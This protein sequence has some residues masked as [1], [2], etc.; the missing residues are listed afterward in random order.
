[1]RSALFGF[2]PLTVIIVLMSTLSIPLHWIITLCI[3]AI[4]AGARHFN[5]FKNSFKTNLETSSGDK[6][7]EKNKKVD[8]FEF[9]ITPDIIGFFAA[10][11]TVALLFHGANQYPYLEDDDPWIH[12]LGVNQIAHT[13]S[14]R[15]PV[16]TNAANFD[17]WYLEPYPPAFD[18]LL[19]MLRQL[20][21]STVFTLKFF[22]ALLAGVAVFAF[23]FW[24]KDLFSDS[25][26]LAPIAA[27]FIST[28]PGF[29]SHFIWAQTL[30]MVLV[31]VAFMAFV[32]LKQD[33]SF[34]L[35]T[36]VCVSAVLVTQPTVAL[37]FGV[38]SCVFLI[39]Q[40]AWKNTEFSKN[41]FIALVGGLLLA[42][43]I[44]W[45]PAFLK[46]GEKQ[47]LF[48]LGFLSSFFHG[49]TSD[50]TSGGVVYN[51]WDF[52][53]PP[54]PSKMDQAVGIGF[55][56]VLLTLIALYSIIK[57]VFVRKLKA[58]AL[59]I[60][61]VAF[62]IIGFLGVQGNA[63]PI[64]LFPHRFWVFLAIPVA[65]FGAL[66]IE[67]IIVDANPR[68]ALII[69]I[70]GLIIFS[71]SLSPRIEVQT[72]QWPPGAAWSSFDEV[73][74]YSALLLALPPDT[75]VFPI[76]A[77]DSKIAGFD[78]LSEPWDSQYKE[79]KKSAFNR[80]SDEVYTFLK[81]RGY[82]YLIIDVSCVKIASPNATQEKLDQYA[83]SKNYEF[84]KPSIKSKLNSQTQ[85]IQTSTA[86]LFRLR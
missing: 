51:L 19:G 50:D 38:I 52:L 27:V 35:Q 57:D 3:G 86:F 69:A 64:K 36:L 11:F 46:F 2:A 29:M 28:I 58:D 6:K 76:C 70:V 71:T 7:S 45:V 26:W 55:G 40:F 24:I 14:A 23:Y 59:W 68:K 54:V 75:K 12:A 53:F 25:K 21:N 15:M 30:A 20:N 66:V 56:L 79:F 42:C 8:C 13:F 60:F 83:S 47:F 74:E 32:K 82:S 72:S 10:L 44:F 9:R 80:S 16:E 81:S 84:V 43:I 41:I 78:K 63:L 22:N 5:L 61:F 17:R 73:F 34:I 31:F 49:G 4:G 1:M 48:G 85:Q 62:L 18:I 67:K 77:Y 39:I 65:V 37:T 33:F